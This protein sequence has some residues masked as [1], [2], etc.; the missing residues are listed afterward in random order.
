M[1]LTEKPGAV[2]LEIPENLASENVTTKPLPVTVLS[3]SVPSIGALKSAKVLIDQSIHPF[4]IIG[5]GVIRD[6]A[7]KEVQAFIDQLCCPVTTSFMAKG[8]L[9]KDHPENYFTFGFTNYPSHNRHMS[10][11]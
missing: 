11:V 6:G 7:V 5:N 10:I 8:I 3:E 2:V 1:A 9:P 4:I